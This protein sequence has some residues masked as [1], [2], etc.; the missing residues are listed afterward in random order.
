MAQRDS[1]DVIA[2]EVQYIENVVN[3]RDIDLGFGISMVYRLEVVLKALETLVPFFI[4]GNYFAVEYKFGNRL[5]AK[6]GD[7]G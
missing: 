4:H 2:I 6:V 7:Q 3:Q 5:T 1:T